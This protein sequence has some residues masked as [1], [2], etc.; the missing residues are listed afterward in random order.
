MEA[1]MKA[2]IKIFQGEKLV[3]RFEYEDHWN[4]CATEKWAQQV[5]KR[6]FPYHE[7]FDTKK[8]KN[9]NG[10]FSLTPINFKDS[11]SNW[12][13]VEIRPLE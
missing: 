10:W 9:G 11:K 5:L 8:L 7:T 3:K 4:R 2:E 12:E 1:I 13:R 6:S